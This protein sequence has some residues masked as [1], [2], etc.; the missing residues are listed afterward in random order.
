MKKGSN[1]VMAASLTTIL[2]VPVSIGDSVQHSESTPPELA[3]VAVEGSCPSGA[4]RLR[5]KIRPGRSQ[6]TAISAHARVRHVKP[7]SLWWSSIH[8]ERMTSGSIIGST[9]EG[10]LRSS[11]DGT[12]DIYFSVPTSDRQHATFVLTEQRGT[13]WCRGLLNSSIRED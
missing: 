10:P 11:Q 1:S 7:S 8:I 2:L 9:S 3:R 4:G 12:I 5:V 6:A 13:G